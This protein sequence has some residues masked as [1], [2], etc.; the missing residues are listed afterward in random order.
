MR[1]RKTPETPI[2]T[3]IRTAAA[4]YAANGQKEHA[5]GMVQAADMLDELAKRATAFVVR[6]EDMTPPAT[7]EIFGK[8]FDEIR[9]RLAKLEAAVFIKS[10]IRFV[11]GDS[12]T[13][14]QKP[15][16]NGLLETPVFRPAG[17]ATEPRSPMDAK[18]LAVLAQRAP[19]PTTGAQLAILTGYSRSG[20]F[21]GALAR[22]RKAGWIDGSGK[23][24]TITDAGWPHAPKTDPLPRGTAL[25]DF[26]CER[27]GTMGGAL[28]RAIVADYPGEVWADE[29]AQR[30]GYK[31]SGS[32]SGAL[33]VLRTLDLVTKRGRIRAS[34]ELMTGIG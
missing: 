14:A 26:W 33:A 34:E 3:Q 6:R 19:K 22:L 9:A 10:R 13:M 17:S 29:L 21:S 15:V 12:P 31:Q 16:A 11:P 23:Y 27:V 7:P 1:R 4:V 28:L 2:A 25:L 5:Q 8:N 30:T 24:L 20:S 32:F 18:M